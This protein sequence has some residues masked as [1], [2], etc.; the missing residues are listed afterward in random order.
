[1]GMGSGPRGPV[2]GGGYAQ[3][4]SMQPARGGS[5]AA[6]GYGGSNMPSMGG[7]QRGSSAPSSG[8]TPVNTVLSRTGSVP[9]G[10]QQQ[11]GSGSSGADLLTLLTKGGSTML[12]PGLG[13]AVTGY[14]NAAS[15]QTQAQAARGNQQQDMFADAVRLKLRGQ[16]SG[17]A[18]AGAAAVDNDGSG[19]ADSRD[20]VG[21]AAAVS[22]ATPTSTAAAAAAVV[23][24]GFG[25]SSLAVMLR[26][27]ERDS[28]LLGVGADA[29][30]SGVN[31]AS[32][33]PLL[34]S[35]ATPWAKDPITTDSAFTLPA[36][37]ARIQMRTFHFAKFDSTTLLYIFY[38]QPRDVQQAH[39][40]AELYAREWR[41][42]K[43]LKLW[44]RSAAAEAVADAKEKGRPV[45]P[46]QQLP[47][48]W[49][50]FDSSSWEKR[51]FV[52]NSSVLPAGFLSEAECTQRPP[53]PQA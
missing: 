26:T 11:G 41:Y 15:G 13:G 48:G 53:L 39:A 36:C 14:A 19:F 17:A 33:D 42:H 31:Y 20:H 1:M 38:S 37:Y 7:L 5:G 44:F 46:Q 2:G 45:P 47:A 43:D 24:D 35:F 34:S 16:P 40:A 3:A 51:P 10:G 8:P 18:R 32:T 52:G 12:P 4:G 6:P 50:Y 9:V 49:I 30:S 22:S 28:H 23:G 29:F 25:L 21:S 27:P